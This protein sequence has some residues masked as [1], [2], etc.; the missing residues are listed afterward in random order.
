[1]LPLTFASAEDYDKVQPSDRVSL[2]GLAGLA[3]GKVRQDLVLPL[4]FPYLKLEQPFGKVSQ[5]KHSQFISIE[6]RPAGLRE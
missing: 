5:S 4:S 3:P 2:T 6:S 1:M